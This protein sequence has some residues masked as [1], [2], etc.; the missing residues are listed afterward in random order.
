GLFQAPSDLPDDNLVTVQATS[1][2]DPSKFGS[3]SFFLT[4]GPNVTF[5]KPP[6]D[7]TS[8]INLQGPPLG[9]KMASSK[10]KIYLTWV[11]TNL[12]NI[13]HL[14]Y[15]VGDKSGSFSSPHDVLDDVKTIIQTLGTPNPENPVIATDGNNIFIAWDDNITTNFQVYL[16]KGVVGSSI[17]FAPFAK[18]SNSNNPSLQAETSSTVLQQRPSMVSSPE[19]NVDLSWEVA[20]GSEYVIHYI[21]LDKNGYK[22]RSTDIPATATPNYQ[23]FS[24]VATDLNGNISITWRDD[25]AQATTPNIY[26]SNWPV[27]QGGFTSPPQQVET[28]LFT[29]SD[30]YAMALNTT[31][32]PFITWSITSSQNQTTNLFTAS[33]TGSSFTVPAF[34]ENGFTPTL[35]IDFLNYADLSW[36]DGSQSVYFMKGTLGFTVTSSYQTSGANPVMDIDEGG[37]VN[38]L[39]TKSS[40]QN[41]STWFVRG[42]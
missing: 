40:G 15:S 35:K 37:R 29:Q 13:T 6:A 28:A 25:N 27:G 26:Y 31:G 17:T 42:E 11:A 9:L 1:T 39:Y 20:N 16:V 36:W 34:R 7:V 18:T 19:G 30:S 33:N 41:I 12:Y 14:W 32:V 24:S 3:V 38:L 10:G 2:G 4:T 21:E 23:R 5:S 8:V 22:L